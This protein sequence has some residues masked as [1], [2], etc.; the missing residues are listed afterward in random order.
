VSQ[1]RCHILSSKSSYRRTRLCLRLCLGYKRPLKNHMI[2]REITCVT[3]VSPPRR[4]PPSYKQAIIVVFKEV[5]KEKLGLLQGN[6]P[7]MCQLGSSDL[8]NFKFY[9][10]NEHLLKNTR[11]FT[12]FPQDGN[13][14][15]SIPLPLNFWLHPF[16]NFFFSFRSRQQKKAN[17]SILQ[18]P[19]SNSSRLKR[20]SRKVLSFIITNRFCIKRN[21]VKISP[22]IEIMYTKSTLQSVKY[23]V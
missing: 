2:I 13:K 7:Y 6:L 10:L 16:L 20:R 15:A 4:T 11:I 19:T 8:L 21:N 18:N 9:K 22:K 3:R 14:R 17:L 1:L 12:Q 5:K 23:S